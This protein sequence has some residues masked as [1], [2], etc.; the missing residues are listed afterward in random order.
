MTRAR[1]T[2]RE[3]LAG[4]GV[5]LAGSALRSGNHA[6]RGTAALSSSTGA[7]FIIEGVPPAVARK[8]LSG[9]T[10]VSAPVIRLEADP[11]RQWRSPQGA[12]LAARGARLLGATTWPQFLIVRGLA[13]ES[14]R[15]VRFQ[16]TDGPSGTITW[17]IS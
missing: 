9:L 17:L 15:R 2:R 6:A 11:V 10:Q 5:V 4:A 13:E 8:A 3:L 7:T 12:Q 14:G 1:L 16:H